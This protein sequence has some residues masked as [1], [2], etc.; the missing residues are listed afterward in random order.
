MDV[1]HIILAGNIPAFQA[2]AAQQLANLIL[3]PDMLLDFLFIGHS[4]KF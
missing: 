1:I 4:Q 3:F 2:A